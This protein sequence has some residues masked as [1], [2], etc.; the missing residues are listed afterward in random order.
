MLKIHESQQIKFLTV[1]KP[2]AWI[3]VAVLVNTEGDRIVSVSAPKIVKIVPKKAA[4][5]LPGAC[6]ESMM[7]LEG[8]RPQMVYRE[9]VISPYVNAVVE[10]PCV[11]AWV[12]ARPPTINV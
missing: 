1:E 6:A 8:A 10:E 9:P 2:T 7:L 5:A 3:I 12:G 11:L 4:C